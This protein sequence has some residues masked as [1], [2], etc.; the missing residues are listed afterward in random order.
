MKLG[1]K[2]IRIDN[3]IWSVK[4]ANRIEVNI[5]PVKIAADIDG[6]ATVHTIKYNH[7]RIVKIEIVHGIP[8]RVFS[9]S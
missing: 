9:G 1:E 7:V 4:Q 6:F 5:R 2:S 8:P 3:K